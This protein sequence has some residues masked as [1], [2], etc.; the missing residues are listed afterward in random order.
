MINYGFKLI[1]NLI[2]FYKLLQNFN[3]CQKKII[4]I[5]I[6][7][8]NLDYLSSRITIILDFNY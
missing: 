7:K 4:K 2:Y 8:L 1:D 3:Y 6:N 5:I